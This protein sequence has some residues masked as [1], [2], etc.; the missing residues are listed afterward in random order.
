[1]GG[2]PRLREEPPELLL[3]DVPV[4]KDLVV[5]E[6]HDAESLAL[7]PAC[8]LCIL[9]CELRVLSAVSRLAL[10]LTPGVL[11][12]WADARRAER[13]LRGP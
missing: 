10:P 3:D 5:P 13:R 7:E 2:T 11:R 1:M 6:P 8:P 9:V 12:Y 4:L